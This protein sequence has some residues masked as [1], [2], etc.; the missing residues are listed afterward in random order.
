[1]PKN[2]LIG[3]IT[4]Y[5]WDDVAPF[6]NSYV[7]AGFENCD[8]V[9]F[10]A[11][12]SEET[13]NKIRACGVTVLPIPEKYINRRIVIYRFKLYL[14]FLKTRPGTYD[15]IL[16]SDIRDVIFQR[17]LFRL[18]DSSK[19]F[20]GVALEDAN[21]VDDQQY[22]AKWVI[23]NY[24]D[25]IYQ[26]VKD[27]QTI[28]MGTLWGTANEVT[29]FFRELVNELESSSKPYNIINDQGSANVIIYY[30]R[31]FADIVRPSSNHDG[32]VMTIG[33]TDEKNIH[34]D[35]DGNVLNDAGEIA[36]VVH[37]YDRKP[38]LAGELNVKYSAGMS[39]LKKLSLRYNLL[40]RTFGFLYRMHRR[41]FIFALKAAITTRLERR[42]KRRKS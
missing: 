1:M 6:F 2:L 32:Y 3:S 25:D 17:D 5:I 15:M 36:A 24:G 7:Q 10:T 9:M 13:L 37:Q 29:A 42:R 33:L 19:P 18:C 12:M 40:G 31:N 38:R 23:D 20:L 39:G 21:I 22:N 27:K 11:N 30:K 34:T 28:C 35:S 8:C 4:N 41:G 14:D 16:T 26:A